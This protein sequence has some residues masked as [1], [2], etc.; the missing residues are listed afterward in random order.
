VY[1]CA[2]MTVVSSVCMC[3]CLHLCVCVCVLAGESSAIDQSLCRWLAHSATQVLQVCCSV[4]Q[5]IA[6]YCSVLQCVAVCCSVLQCVAL[7]CSALQYVAVH[8]DGKL[9]YF[10]TQMIIWWT[11]YGNDLCHTNTRHVARINASCLTSE[12]VKP[13]L[14]AASTRVICRCRMCVAAWSV[15]QCVV[16][17]S[18]AAVCCSVCNADYLYMYYYLF[19][20]V[21][22]ATWLA[23]ALDIT[24]A[25]VCLDTSVHKCDVVHS[26]S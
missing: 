14:Q 9:Q 13:W 17:T 19:I 2:H 3:A 21:V 23:L 10:L 20:Y 5:C 22:C 8:Q 16:K 18:C 4:L 7:C 26:N 11:F 25:C 15:L 24:H 6:V 12:R 1:M